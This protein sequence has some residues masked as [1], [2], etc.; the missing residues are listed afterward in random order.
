ME[1]FSALTKLWMTGRTQL[2]FCQWLF[3]VLGDNF[4]FFRCG[5]YTHVGLPC[6]RKYTP[7][8]VILA[9]LPIP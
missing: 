7:V 5:V 4:F 3:Y 8:M 2:H 1:T 6:L 9:S